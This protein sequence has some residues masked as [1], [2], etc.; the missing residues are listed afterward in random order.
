[1][2]IFN[3]DFE[4]SLRSLLILDAYNTAL[5]PDTIKAVDLLSIYGKQFGISSENLHGDNSFSFTEVASG[6]ETIKTAL[7]ELVR[8]GFVTA[9]TSTTGFMYRI[10]SAG[11]SYCERL[12]SDYA[13][14]FKQAVNIANEFVRGKSQSEVQQFLYRNL[15]RRE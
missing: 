12:T 11:S 8:D 1:M 2:K 14:E 6:Q 13:S 9:I 5:D 15:L 7:K 4:I 10:N 3:S